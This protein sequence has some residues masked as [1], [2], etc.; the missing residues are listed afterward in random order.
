VKHFLVKNYGAGGGFEEWEKDGPFSNALKAAQAL[1]ITIPHMKDRAFSEI[2]LVGGSL[3]SFIED[4]KRSYMLRGYARAWRNDV[5]A[6]FRRV[7]LDTLIA[8]AIAG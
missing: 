2:Q 3:S 4:E 1:T 7:G 6:E 8:A 5:W